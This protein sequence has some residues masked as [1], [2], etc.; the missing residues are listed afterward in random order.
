MKAEG[1]TTEG[2]NCIY[3]G[4]ITAEHPELSEGHSACQPT[5]LVFYICMKHLDIETMVSVT[6]WS[7]ISSNF[8]PCVNEEPPSN[9]SIGI[10]HNV[11]VILL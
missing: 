7:G 1:A 10:A 8:K 9:R 11:L 5:I 3:S 4:D 6:E 2:R